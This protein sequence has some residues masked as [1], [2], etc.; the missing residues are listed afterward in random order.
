MQTVTEPISRS[1][2]WVDVTYLVTQALDRES[3]T[4]GSLELAA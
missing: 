3:A 4:R 1:T 2:Y